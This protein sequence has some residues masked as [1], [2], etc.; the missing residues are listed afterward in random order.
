MSRAV[1]PLRC[2]FHSNSLSYIFRLIIHEIKIIDIPLFHEIKIIKPNISHEIKIIKPNI[3][4]EIKIK[5]GAKV[6]IIL[7]I[8]KLFGQKMKEERKRVKSFIR[9][10]VRFCKI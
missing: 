6:M 2:C 5:D 10:T 4:H 8:P 1:S 9:I 3:S 7:Q